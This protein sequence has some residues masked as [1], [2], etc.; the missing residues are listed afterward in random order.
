VRIAVLHPSAAESKSPFVAHDPAADP[1]RHDPE[2][3]YTNFEIRKS[4]AVAQ[5]IALAREEYDVALNLCDGAW[6]EDR[7][8]VEVGEALER[9]GLAFT[10]A[11]ARLYEPSRTAMKIAAHSVGVA[12]P[13]Y[14][15]SVEDALEDLR[16]PVIVKHPNSYSSVGLTA[17]SRVDDEAGLRREFEKMASS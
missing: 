16:F 7:A 17:A 13:A 6:A 15:E 2:N 14:A 5:V 3:E 1:A 8:G 4:T 11:A 9:V 12:I 10:G